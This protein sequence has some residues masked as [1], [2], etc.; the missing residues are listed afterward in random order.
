VTG[1][2]VWADTAP[3][4]GARDALDGDTQVDVAIVGG[5]YTGLWTA[6]SLRQADPTLRVVVLEADRIGAG[7]SGRNGGWCSALMPVTASRDMQAAMYETVREIERVVDTEGIDC[8]FER[9]GY[10]QLAR[11]PAQLKRVR[12]DVAGTHALG[13]SDADHRVLE[14]AETA[15]LLR[16]SRVLGA[17]FTPHCAAIHPLRLVR[18]LADAVERHGATVYEQTRVTAFEPGVVTTDSGTVRAEVVVRATEAGTVRLP[19]HRRDVLP[20]YSLMIATEP[21]PDHVWQTIGLADRPTFNDARHLIIY[22]QRTDDSRLAFGGRGAPYHFGSRTDARFEQ[23][24]PTHHG[25]RDILVD[26]FPVLSDVRITH[27]WGGALAIPRDWHASVGFDRAT[28]VAWA[29]GYIGDGVATTNLAGRTLADLILRRETALT[30]LPWVGHRSP[31]WE[32]EPV[33]W[34]GVTTVS[35]LPERVDRAENS[36]RSARFS[37]ATLHRFLG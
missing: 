12:A 16:A 26:L 3:S 11:N 35:K 14:P 15:N 20:V 28:G 32:P 2:S 36:G 34:L 4:G 31:R 7:A 24:A 27:R 9:G 25:L 33:R 21:L 8:G 6:Y 29:G 23:H 10:V 22:G 18:G 37:S 5:G 30:R 17:S 19:G 13:F 1:A